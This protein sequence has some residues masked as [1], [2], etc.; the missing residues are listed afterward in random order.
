MKVIPYPYPQ[1]DGT[2]IDCYLLLAE[3]YDNMISN[4]SKSSKDTQKIVERFKIFIDKIDNLEK[5]NED[6]LSEV[7]L[8]KKNLVSV[9]DGLRALGGDTSAIDT[10]IQFLRDNATNA[11]YIASRYYKTSTGKNNFSTTQIYQHLGGVGNTSEIK[12]AEFI[13]STL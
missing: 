1:D 3:E 12:M 2:I 6:L 13:Y 8:L 10:E 11:K 5:T 9:E 7:N 4:I